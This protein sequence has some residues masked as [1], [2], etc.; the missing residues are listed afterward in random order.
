[1]TDTR[2]SLI[3][4]LSWWSGWATDRGHDSLGLVLLDAKD[5]IAKDR[6]ADKEES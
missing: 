1:M 6:P 2:E 3:A 4:E 5:Q